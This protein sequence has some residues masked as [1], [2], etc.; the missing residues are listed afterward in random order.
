MRSLT[1]AEIGVN[2]KDL[3]AGSHESGGRGALDGFQVIDLT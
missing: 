3:I 2:D 1:R